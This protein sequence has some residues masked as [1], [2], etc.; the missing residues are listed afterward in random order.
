MKYSRI[1]TQSASKKTDIETLIRSKNI[2][3]TDSR[4]ITNF[5][6]KQRM[7]KRKQT[8]III[9]HQNINATRVYFNT[10]AWVCLNHRF[11]K[12]NRN[13]RTEKINK[14]RMELL[15]G[16]LHRISTVKNNIQMNFS[17][18]RKSIMSSLISFLFWLYKWGLGIYG[19]FV[20]TVFSYRPGTYLMKLLCNFLICI[21]HTSVDLRLIKKKKFDKD[22]IKSPK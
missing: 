7:L 12:K 18:L 17:L 11:L 19:W 5:Q 10:Y 22:K 15:L 14:K 20:C 4:I 13:N 21:L 8:Y 16:I 3:N 1:V 9:L 6:G 2:G